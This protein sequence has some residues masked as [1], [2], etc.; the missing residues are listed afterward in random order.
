MTDVV[1]KRYLYDP[2]DCVKHDNS[3]GVRE[4]I[5]KNVFLFYSINI[6]LVLVSDLGWVSHFFHDKLLAP[7]YPYGW[8]KKR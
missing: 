7:F 6:I 3:N 1:L 5:L 4:S 2:I 8:R